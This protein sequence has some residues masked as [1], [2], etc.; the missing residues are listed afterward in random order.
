MST[1]STGVGANHFC[2]ELPE[3]EDDQPRSSPSTKKDNKITQGVP[4]K[5]RSR[6][7]KPKSVSPAKEDES[8]MEGSHIEIEGP[9]TTQIQINLTPRPPPSEERI[10][11]LLSNI[12][13]EEIVNFFKD[14][15]ME[16]IPC[17]NKEKLAKA[18]QSRVEKKFADRLDNLDRSYNYLEHRVAALEVGLRNM[19]Q[20]VDGLH[21]SALGVWG[22]RAP[23]LVPFAMPPMSPMGGSGG[24]RVS[25]PPSQVPGGSGMG[26]DYHHSR[27]HGSDGGSRGG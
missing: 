24:S 6:P 27:G 26:R 3:S 18:V 4:S 8:M 16:E 14:R 11:E 2:P 7:I 25:R 10:R 19:G 9:D 22:G 15:P 17:Q 20:A 23:G 12:V 13:E 21:Y 5:L 1:Y